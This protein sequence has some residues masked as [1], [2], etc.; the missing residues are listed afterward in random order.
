MPFQACPV[1]AFKVVS[2]C[3]Q[4]DRFMVTWLIIIRECQEICRARVRS[5]SLEPS[6]ISP[7]GIRIARL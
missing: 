1:V 6:E 7:I 2:M 5:I 4:Q 3:I